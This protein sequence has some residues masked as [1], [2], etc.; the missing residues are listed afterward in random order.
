MR[1]MFKRPDIIAFTVLPLYA[2]AMLWQFDTIV[3]TYYMGSAF[4]Y[5]PIQ[6]IIQIIFLVWL[7][8]YTQNFLRANRKLRRSIGL[9]FFTL[10]II[11]FA[12]VA[13]YIFFFFV[14]CDNGLFCSSSDITERL[15]DTPIISAFA[16]GIIFWPT[17]LIGIIYGSVLLRSTRRHK[18]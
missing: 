3:R 17:L 13:A 10:N 2:V 11:L 8:R 1:L 18:K 7:I 9:S 6:Y 15:H 14:N 5:N 12:I 16:Y 4:I